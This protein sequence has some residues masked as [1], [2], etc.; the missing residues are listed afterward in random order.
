MCIKII[1]GG[2]PGPARFDIIEKKTLQR[3]WRF[4]TNRDYTLKYSLKLAAKMCLKMCEN[5][6]K[7]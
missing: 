6:V 1:L 3:H 2:S 5:S 4:G 7:K